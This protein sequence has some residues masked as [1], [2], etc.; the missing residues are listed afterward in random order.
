MRPDR[1]R[2]IPQNCDEIRPLLP[3]LVGL[4]G[5]LGG[6]SDL[7]P[8]FSPDHQ[9]D[10]GLDFGPDLEPGLRPQGRASGASD[11]V[12]SDFAADMPAIR[13]HLATCAGCRRELAGWQSLRGALHGAWTGTLPP[14]LDLAMASIPA[15]AAGQRRA[16]FLRA[17]SLLPARSHRLDALFRGRPAWIA[18]P[19]SFATVLTL[20][21]LGVTAVLLGLALWGGGGNL[22]QA[23]FGS[24]PPSPAPDEVAASIDVSSPR[25]G[26]GGPAP[27]T[28]VLRA[29][30]VAD[31]LL[32]PAR[33]VP[34]T[35]TT[36]A[37]A[38]PRTSPL[39]APLNP[40]DAQAPQSR[41]QPFDPPRQPEHP[42]DPDH[43][44]DPEDPSDPGN[45]SNPTNPDPP[46]PHPTSVPPEPTSVAATA[47][48]APGYATPQPTAVAR[49]AGRV[50]DSAGLGLA[51]ALVYLRPWPEG[52]GRF[53]L[54]D[55]DDDGSFVLDLPAGSYR[56][57]VEA[58]GYEP[59]W[60]GGDVADVI[61]LPPA[62]ERR[63]LT[64]RLGLAGR[65][66]FAPP[67]PSPTSVTLPLPIP[68]PER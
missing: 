24:N 37:P 26:A 68:A 17:L 33:P 15:E 6:L 64:V 20:L 45:P 49:V 9:A 16:W 57:W 35:S 39:P 8:E 56:L 59:A 63:D 55:T 47:T 50:E 67:L 4:D 58:D 30:P 7:G 1:K 41:P 28:P 36:T 13:A 66:P 21:S 27:A 44:S 34:G 11:R 38:G 5:A 43:P 54:T 48:P 31:S 10:R 25:A 61:E 42:S 32:A 18:T 52:E 2:L 3:D 29:D 19:Q 40:A 53:L 46:S 62:A 12:S 14:A 23:W 65:P 60:Y 51:W 22:R